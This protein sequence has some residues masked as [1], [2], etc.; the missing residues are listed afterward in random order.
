MILKLAMKHQAMDR[1][2]VFTDHDPGMTLSYFTAR[3]A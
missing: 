1:Y 2:K 3:S